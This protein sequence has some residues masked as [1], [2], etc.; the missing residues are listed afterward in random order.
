[1][2]PICQLGIRALPSLTGSESGGNHPIIRTTVCRYHL[3]PK[4]GFAQAG[5]GSAAV[6]TIGDRKVQP[7]NGRDVQS[8]AESVL[9]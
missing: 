4:E 3:I 9:N 1:M 7:L 6:L 5:D 2:K 8:D